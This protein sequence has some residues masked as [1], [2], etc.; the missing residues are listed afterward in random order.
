MLNDLSPVA[1]Y[2][3][4]NYNTP[5]NSLEFERETNRILKEVEKECSWMFQ[6]KHSDGRLGTIN[7]TVWSDVFICPECANE[8]VFWDAAVDHDKGKVNDNFLCPH[9]T[10]Q[11][12][13]RKLDRSWVTAFDMDINETIKQVKQVPVLINYSVDGKRFEKNQMMLTSHSSEGSMMLQY[14][15]LS[16]KIE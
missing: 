4:H 3:A 1:T 15:I 2:I 8:I 6:T 14:H 5:V 16:P 12:T 9:C 10:A 13:K 11:L 7:Y